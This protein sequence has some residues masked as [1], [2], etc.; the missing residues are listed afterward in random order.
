MATTTTDH[1][2]KGGDITT[3]RL[4]QMAGGFMMT[5]MLY[6][7]TKLHI[8]DLLK[9]GPRTTT[10]LAIQSGSNEDALYRV[11][12]AL[13]SSGVF[14]EVAPR[15]FAL[16][17]GSHALLSG[18]SG[19]IRD[20]V[21]WMGN[22]FH[23]KVW[24]ELP[25]SVATGK[26]AVDYIYG[27]PAFEAIND[28]PEIA[29]DFNTAMTCLSNQ[30]APAV[31]DA[32][33]FSGINTLMDIAGGHG[34]VLCGI[35]AR[36]PRM[37][38]I[39]FDMQSVIQEAKCL[40]CERKMEQRCIP[41]AGD[42]FKS[43]PPGADA[44]YLQHIIHDWDDEHALQILKNLRHAMQGYA[45]RRVIIVDCVLP[46][47]SEPHFGKLVDLEMLLMPG[48]RE[49]TEREWRELFAKAGFQITRIVPTRSANSV[50]EARLR[51]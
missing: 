29:Y 25:Y 10:D 47:N 41:I 37:K 45:E 36:Y 6:T 20:M 26:T 14:D 38:G 13:A 49:R 22:P 34:A 28:N 39:L 44:Y 24:S 15:T 1:T 3:E 40:I 32:Y 8:P 50:I 21:L 11:L 18:E 31:L 42:F 46:E 35:L 43:I 33:D 9:N 48:G 12:R 30:L 7:V 5:A 2:A 19:S 17:T 51:G 23:F 27:K 16:P 4:M